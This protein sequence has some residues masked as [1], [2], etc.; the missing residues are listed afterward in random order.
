MIKFLKE[1]KL[2]VAMII[3]GFII[4]GLFYLS[5]LNQPAS[6]SSVPAVNNTSANNTN[7]QN[8]APS[9]SDHVDF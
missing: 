4:G 5:R 7:S 6:L 8:S 1:N 9:T 3:A 2:F